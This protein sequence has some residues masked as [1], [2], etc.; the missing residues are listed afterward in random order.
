LKVWPPTREGDLARVQ[1]WNRGDPD[2]IEAAH[3]EG[4]AR[5]AMKCWLCGAEPALVEVTTPIDTQRRYLP[6]R[7]PPALDGHTHAERPPTPGELE[8]AGHEAL[9]R[10]LDMA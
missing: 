8:Q 7:W 10:I 6:G 4:V 5:A 3:T 2:A 1:A 9:S